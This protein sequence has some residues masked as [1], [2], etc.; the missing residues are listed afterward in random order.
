[1]SNEVMS[2]V[3]EGITVLVDNLT[4]FVPTSVSIGSVTTLDSDEV[5][6]VVNSGTSVDQ[7]LDFGIL[8]F[9]ATTFDETIRCS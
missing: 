3:S 5:A 4:V 6:M 1:M 2:D 7:V 8:S 9:D